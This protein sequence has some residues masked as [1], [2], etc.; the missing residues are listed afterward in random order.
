MTYVQTLNTAYTGLLYLQVDDGDFKGYVYPCSAVNYSMGINRIPSLIAHLGAGR[1]I[2]NPSLA[3]D[4]E[5][6]VVSIQ[7]HDETEMVTR[8]LRCSVYEENRNFKGPDKLIFKGYLVSAEI[9]YTSTSKAGIDYK[10]T[11]MGLAAALFVSPIS[12][13]MEASF[14]QIMD[15][16]GTNRK[17]TFEEAL[18]TGSEYLA[19]GVPLIPTLTKRCAKLPIHKR[20]AACVETIKKAGSFKDAT[21]IFENKTI[22]DADVME[23]FGGDTKLKVDK[24]GGSDLCDLSYTESLANNFLYGLQ[25]ES[26]YDTIIRT[27][28]SLEF[29]LQLV[30]RWSC[31]KKDDFKTEICPITAWAPRDIITL[32]ASD[33]S[34]IRMAHNSTGALNT[35]DVLIVNFDEILSYT[36]NGAGT[37]LP[38][39]YG[40]AAKD[41][42]VEKALQSF[43]L[44]NDLNSL[45]NV[46]G[47]KYRVRMVNAPKW[48]GCVATIPGVVDN[49]GT[50]PQTGDK[51]QLPAENLEQETN[52]NNTKK[53]DVKRTE[54]GTSA[55]SMANTLAKVLFLY[56][57]MIDDCV[58]VQVMPN[59]RF[60]NDPKRFLE[61]SLGDTLVV[62]LTN[63]GVVRSTVVLK[64]V[65]KN[66]QYE[67][68]SSEASGSRYWIE[69]ERVR[70]E[71]VKVP[72]I[73]CPIYSTA[74]K[75]KEN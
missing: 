67:Q 57:Y 14:S 66:I 32:T 64:G 54:S 35:P 65:L 8:F 11:C 51:S 40:I 33:I 23:A 48:L 61:N 75:F 71:H 59:L 60:G 18:R 17:L 74:P 63:S 43:V 49:K 38:N 1:S 5:E 7:E 70:L 3:Y 34:N 73:E 15:T 28:T 10:V 20:V 31:D 42:K 27:L 62:D 4:P 56:M 36:N 12:G 6:L 50:N 53:P 69:L 21:E 24:L 19:Q 72:D 39:V 58:T 47:K 45:I 25:S 46:Q 44:T 37:G 29:S 9:L 52:Q 2:T 55:F 22:F 16:K 26:V 30:P 68:S 41:E 13:Y